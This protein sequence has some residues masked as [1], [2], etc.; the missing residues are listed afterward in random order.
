LKAI[1]DQPTAE[2]VRLTRQHLE[3]AIIE[4]KPLSIADLLVEVPKVK[5]DEIGGNED[6]KFQVR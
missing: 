4:S 1:K 6:I 5:W 3:A 2:R